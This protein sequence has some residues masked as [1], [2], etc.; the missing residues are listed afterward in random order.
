MK[1]G[2]DRLWRLARLGLFLAG[3]HVGS[4]DV[5]EPSVEDYY[6]GSFAPVAFVNTSFSAVLPLLLKGRPFVVTDG[7]RGLPMASWDC[8]SA[9][10]LFPNSRIRHEGGKSDVNGVPMAS[11]WINRTKPYRNSEQFP[12]GAP[13]FRPF[14]WDITKAFMDEGHRKWGKNAQQVADKIVQSSKVPYWLPQQDEKF[15]GK[16][17]EMWFHPPGAG[18]V[19]HMD[20][21]CQTTVS[22]CFSGARKWRMMVPPAEPHKDGYSDGMIYGADDQTRKGEWQPTFEF[23][24]PAGSAV[25]VYP[26][27]V[28]ETLSNGEQCSSSVSQTFT[29]PVA[30]AYY[31]SFWPRFSLVKED[32]GNCAE[33]VENMV[34]LG[35]GKKVPP[36]KPKAAEKTGAAFVAKVDSDKDGILSKSEISEVNQRT[37]YDGK[38]TLEELISFHDVDDDGIVTVKEAIESWVMFATSSFRVASRM[39]HGEL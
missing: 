39:K 4:I 2:L 26:G 15:M 37:T 21:H 32:V 11:D 3:G 20:P 14:Y 5:K 36:A 31:R 30:A 7:A 28:H 8:E 10:K 22:F 6:G 9:Q 25:L 16:M 13:K 18:A 23:D 12:E 17:S 29:L 27:M 38:R 34:T 1:I 33:V 35:S 19:A 24:A